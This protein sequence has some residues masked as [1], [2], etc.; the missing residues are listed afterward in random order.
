MDNASVVQMRSKARFVSVVG[1]FKPREI[2]WCTEEQA[3]HFIQHNLAELIVQTGPTET[4]PAGPTELKKSSPEEQAGQS[5]ASAQS[6]ETGKD[7]GQSSLPADPVSKDAPAKSPFSG[8]V[9]G[10]RE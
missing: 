2:F 6:S 4:K 5:T 1:A 3:K 8:L 10:Q 9:R 7:A